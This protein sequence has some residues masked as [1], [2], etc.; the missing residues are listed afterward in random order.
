M[1]QLYRYLCF[2]L[3]GI[4]LAV[5]LVSLICVI[6]VPSDDCEI[7]I[8]FSGLLDGSFYENIAEYFALK[9]PARDTLAEKFLDFQDWYTLVDA[10]RIT[11]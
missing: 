4:L 1:D 6:F 8:S 2:G 3:L 5:M 10:T 9:F 7:S 11:E